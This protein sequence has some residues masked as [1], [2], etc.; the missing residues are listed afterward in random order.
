[1]IAPISDVESVCRRR[2]AC[3]E[4]MP[5]GMVQIQEPPA[6][7]PA[8]VVAFGY[9]SVVGE[10]IDGTG[11]KRAKDEQLGCSHNNRHGLF[12]TIESLGHGRW[13]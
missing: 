5:E 10:R 3:L 7:D 12:L 6:A 11:R 13:R 1:M 8:T 9:Q 4:E 2:S